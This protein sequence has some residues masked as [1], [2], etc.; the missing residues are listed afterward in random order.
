[1]EALKA[2]VIK[3]LHGTSALGPALLNDLI[4]KSESKI[5]KLTQELQTTELEFQRQK[6]Y[7]NRFSA[8]RT[9]LLATGVTDISCLTFNQLQELAALVLDR[10]ELKARQYR[11]HPLG[12]RGY[13]LL[14]HRC[15]CLTG[16]HDRADIL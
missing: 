10:M 16:M 3:V 9:S 12:L 14:G 5:A 13:C 7:W 8:T 15:R 4:E 11:P 2:E 6:M 1:M